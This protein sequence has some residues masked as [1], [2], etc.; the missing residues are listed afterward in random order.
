MSQDEQQPERRSSA[1]PAQKPREVRSAL[2]MPAD[3]S[4][5]LAAKGGTDTLLYP[6]GERQQSMRG[7]EDT[8]VDI[9]DYIVRITHKIWEEKS[10][11]TIYDTY[12]HNAK[13]TD[14]AGLQYGRDKIV[15]DTLHTINA[16]PD[17][18]LY[19]DEM[20]WAG[21]DETGFHTSHRV[22]IVGHNTGYSRYGPPTGRRVA[23]WCTANCVV[24]ENEIVEEWVIYNTSSLLTQLGFNLREQARRFGNEFQ[25]EIKNGLNDAA[26]GEPERLLGQG[27]PP[28]LGAPSGAF[29]VDTFLRYAY[30]TIWNWRKLELIKEVYAPTLRFHGTTDRELYSRGAYQ[31][32]VLSMLAMF[33]DLSFSMD[34]LYWMGNDDEG[35]LTS[36][37]WSITGTHR[38]YGVYGPPTGRR[39]HMWGVTQHVIQGGVISEEWTFFN[40]FRVMQQLF[41]DAPS[42]AE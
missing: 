35:Y 1:K 28:K 15:A 10:V 36:L 17:V 23:V 11:G 13:V 32:F 30:H 26:Y 39:V 25:K 8:Y 21:D 41:C 27:K 6:T 7:F 18:R 40:E 2:E 34:D 12:A 37:R 20:I 19:A 24:K 14:D 33:P 42:D 16:F 22:L 3:F 5:S 38:G 31:T 4:I 29:N 9:V